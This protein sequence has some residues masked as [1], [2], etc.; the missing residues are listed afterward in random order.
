MERIPVQSSNIASV[1][2]DPV[3]MILEIEFLFGGIYQYFKVTPNVYD[4]LMSAGAKGFY[5]DQ[6]IKKM[7]YQYQR[8]SSQDFLGFEFHSRIVQMMK[9]NPDFTDIQSESRLKI[10]NTPLFVDV[11]CSYRGKRIFV[12]I[13]QRPPFTLDRLLVYISRL[14]QYLKI[15]PH[16]T[17]VLLFPGSMPTEYYNIAKEKHI[18][19]WD[20]ERLRQLFS[21]QL[22]ILKNTPLYHLFYLA[23][24]KSCS[25]S[26]SA[27]FIAELDDISPG[28]DDCYKYQEKCKDIFEYL[29]SPPLGKPHYENRDETNTNRRDIIFPNYT[30]DGFWKFLRN[31]Y[32]ADY[33]VIDAKNYK[34]SI[35]KEAVLQMSNYLKSF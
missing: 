23:P 11:A 19:I 6:H 17:L 14:Q 34:D 4:G 1:G 35:K 21:N 5:F 18:D 27:K 13:K 10:G 25:I 28:R 29:F 33:I 22:E 12:E 9:Q 32:A 20:S 24:N 30:E 31:K 8:I 3:E 26:Q 15:E 7:A 2:Y 16:A